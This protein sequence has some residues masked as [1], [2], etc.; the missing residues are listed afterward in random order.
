MQQSTVDGRLGA[1]YSDEPDGLDS[2]FFYAR[3]TNQQPRDIAGHDHAGPERNR[4]VERSR[5]VRS[6]PDAIA[7]RRQSGGRE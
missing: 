4:S 5:R 2:G 1:I 3:T 7:N 6:M